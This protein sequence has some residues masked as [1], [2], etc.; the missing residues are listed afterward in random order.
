M[1]SAPFKSTDHTSFTAP[2]SKYIGESYGEDPDIYKID[3]QD[4]DTLRQSCSNPE[5][6]EQSAANQLRYYTQLFFLQQKFR[7][8]EAN[9]QIVFCWFNAFGGRSVSSYN[10]GFEKASVLFNLA[11]IYSKLATNQVLDDDDGIKKAASYFQQSAG[12]FQFVSDSL[13]AWNIEGTANT[14]L[15]GLSDFMLAQAQEVFL[16]KAVKGGMKV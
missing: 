11:A 10:I 13:E 1:L 14:Q 7:I 4:L 9:I 8:D 3:L 6:H 15:S 5:P 12:V 16:I 2:L